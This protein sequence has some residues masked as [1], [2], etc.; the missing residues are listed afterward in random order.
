MNSRIFLFFFS[1]LF[2]SCKTT[3]SCDAYFSPVPRHK[4][5]EIPLQDIK[6]KTELMDYHIPEIG[7][8]DEPQIACNIRYDTLSHV[9]VIVTG[10]IVLRDIDETKNTQIVD[11]V[12]I[13]WFAV[14]R[15]NHA[16]EFYS[17]DPQKV[18]LFNYRPWKDCP[19]PKSVRDEIRE[20]FLI[21]MKYRKYHLKEDR[22]V[23]TIYITWPYRLWDTE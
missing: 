2:V 23:K 16:M 13:N 6:Y 18:H 22:E 7:S 1:I 19:L 11:S 15:S 21:R 14:R 5:K 17:N 8:Y 9:T 4:I 3:N 20:D 10:Y 12:A